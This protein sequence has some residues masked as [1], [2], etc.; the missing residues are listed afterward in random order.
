MPIEDALLLLTR[1]F[2]AYMHGEQTG[3]N[4]NATGV[5]NLSERHPEGIQV[6]LF[7]ISPCVVTFIYFLLLDASKFI[8]RKSTDNNSSI[9]PL[10]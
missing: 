7:F 9:R 1:N 4:A 2:D 8:S 3:R 10:N 6:A 5:N